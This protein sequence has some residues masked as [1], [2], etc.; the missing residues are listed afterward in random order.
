LNHPSGVDEDRF[1]QFTSCVGIPCGLVSARG[2]SET[3]NVCSLI[4]LKDRSEIAHIL[5]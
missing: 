1:H 3:G 2:K 5:T 4:Q